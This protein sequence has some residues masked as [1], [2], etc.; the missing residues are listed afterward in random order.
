TRVIESMVR[1]RDGQTIILGGQRQTEN[2]VSSKGVPFLS[3]IPVLGWLF[4]SRTISKNETQ[5]M[6][7]LTPH[8]YY[9]DDNAVSPDDYF[10]KEVNKILDKYDLD[11]KDQKKEEIQLKREQ[12]RN[13]KSDKKIIKEEKPAEKVA[14]KAA[15]DT[16]PA[17]AP[18]KKQLDKE[19][20]P[21]KSEGD[22]SAVVS[23]NQGTKQKRKFQ[24]FWKRKKLKD[25]N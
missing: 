23:T 1:L 3:S 19:T 11:K 21:E 2:V 25:K 18:E 10:G 24:W 12:R 5:M 20:I 16:I 4:S 9:G 8:V 15:F 14:V 22:S 6:I 13:R 7:F 17:T